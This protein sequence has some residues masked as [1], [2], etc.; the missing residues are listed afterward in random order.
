MGTQ[1]AARPRRSDA[2]QVRLTERDISGLLLVAEQ[3]AAPVT[4]WPPRS[5]CRRPG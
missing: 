5:A 3:Y 4:C 2:G 1:A